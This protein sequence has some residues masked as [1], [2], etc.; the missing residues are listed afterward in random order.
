M[1]QKVEQKLSIVTGQVAIRRVIAGN[2]LCSS[3]AVEID[4][5][6]A[7]LS[8]DGAATTRVP[9]KPKIPGVKK[10][11]QNLVKSLVTAPL[12][13]PQRLSTRQHQLTPYSIEGSA[14]DYQTFREIREF[15]RLVSC[16]FYTGLAYARQGL[17]WALYMQG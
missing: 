8:M 10:G 11:L 1:D 7:S 16:M 14:I 4:S 5:L 12:E 6:C 13:R 17:I 9:R 15:S 3:H 2:L